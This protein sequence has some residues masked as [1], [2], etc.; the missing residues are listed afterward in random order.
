M[1]SLSI[2]NFSGRLFDMPAKPKEDGLLA[3]ISYPPSLTS[4]KGSVKVRAQ[5]IGFNDVGDQF[6][7]SD[8]RGH[9]MVYY[10]SQN[11]Y[12]CI[13]KNSKDAKTLAFVSNLKSEHVM[14]GNSD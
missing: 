12:F 5:G 9:I 2:V 13:S 4:N 6:V 1:A 8:S 3:T 10:L 14:V 7:I 11:R